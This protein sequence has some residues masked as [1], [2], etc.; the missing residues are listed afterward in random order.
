MHGELV[1]TQCIAAMKSLYEIYLSKLA[2]KVVQTL[3][4]LVT[5]RALQGL[6]SAAWTMPSRSFVVAPA[7]DI[8]TRTCK[9]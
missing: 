7:K 4:W 8:P 9:G 3:L 2:L 1:A 6:F 5:S